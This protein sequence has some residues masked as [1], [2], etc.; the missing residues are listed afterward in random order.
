MLRDPAQS[1]EEGWEMRANVWLCGG[2]C[3][4]VVRDGE[5]RVVDATSRWARLETVVAWT[6]CMYPGARVRIHRSASPRMLVDLLAGFSA[7]AR[8]GPGGGDERWRS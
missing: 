7:A 6:R 1:G 2:R 5:G 4:A 3:H 8:R